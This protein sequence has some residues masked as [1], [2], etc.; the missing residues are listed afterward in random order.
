VIAW[1]FNASPASSVGAGFG[2]FTSKTLNSIAAF[3]HMEDLRTVAT[4]AQ[5]GAFVNA[6]NQAYV[7]GVG[8]YKLTPAGGLTSL[9]LNGMDG[10]F[11]RQ[12]MA[13]G[14]RQFA[15]RLKPPIGGLIFGNS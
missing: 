7:C 11:W 15:G 10:G 4:G 2:H 6:T 5:T 12:K 1:A 9:Q 13:G 3:I 14:M 8:A